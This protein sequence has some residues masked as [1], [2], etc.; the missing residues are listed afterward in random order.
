MKNLRKTVAI[1]GFFACAV[2]PAR[3]AD[4][5][6]RPIVVELFT[7]QGCS[8]CPPADMLLARLA[9]RKDVIA[10]S[11]PITY[12]DMLGWKD[13]LA[14]EA[15]TRRQ[16]SYAQAMS[17]GGV[18]TPQVVID[19]MEDIVGNRETAIDSAIV[20]HRTYD[21]AVQRRAL[22]QTINDRLKILSIPV[23][24]TA[25]PHEIH[26]VIGQARDRANHDATVWMFRTL[27]QATVKIG[28][29]ENSGRVITYHNVVRDVK[30]IG[31][32]KGQEITLDLPKNEAAIPHD[33]VAVVVQ[34]S[35]YGRIIG[36]AFV[37]HSS[38]YAEQ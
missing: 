23:A 2:V 13:T 18:Y 11:L 37:D 16:K 22:V 28:G 19:G 15:N 31:M 26:I 33:G 20:V 9:Q 30:A 14:S 32:W 3:A 35:G 4:P 25:M 6:D 36:A 12:W 7:S 1:I 17:H 38:Y 27:S 5:V 21:A 24:I 8:S 34:Q 29:G 10:L